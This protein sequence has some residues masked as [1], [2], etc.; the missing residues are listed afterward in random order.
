M[1]TF[2]FDVEVRSVGVTLSPASSGRGP[3]PVTRPCGPRPGCRRMHH[4]LCIR[5]RRADPTKSGMMSTM[6]ATTT[7]TRL[8]RG[9][10]DAV[11]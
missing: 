3:N 5:R 9:A 7:V 4:H 2:A 11:R 10:F 8:G 6:R 1:T